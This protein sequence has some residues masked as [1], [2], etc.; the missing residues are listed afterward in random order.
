MGGAERTARKRRQQQVAGRSSGAKAVSAARRG[1]DGKRVAVIVGV[2]VAVLAVVVGGLIWTNAAKN[3]T[4]GQKIPTETGQTEIAERRDGAVVVL[5]DENAPATIDVYADF[6]CPVCATFDQ[7]YGA[8]IKQKVA[9]GTVQVR[10]HMLPM[11]VEMS[12]P[13]GYSMESANAALLAADAGKFVEFHDSLFA[14]QPEEGKRGYDKDQLIQLG[15]DLG[16]TDKAFAE[17]V[18]NGK[19]E[20]VL[21]EEMERVSADTSLRR[22]FGG[23]RVGFGT[24]TVVANG[25][26]VDIGDPA[27]L[28]KVVGT[29]TS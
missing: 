7:Q 3:A 1:G 16:I 21:T 4:E 24:P 27:W 18:R 5:G 19:Y 28:D 22:D 26:I 20:K 10:Q 15:R 17:G 14:N 8:Q 9:D 13:P 23:G 25:K 2:V 29:A 11:L 6:L 12:D